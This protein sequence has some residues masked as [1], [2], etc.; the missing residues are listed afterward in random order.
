MAIALNKALWKACCSSRGT[1]EAAD[2]KNYLLAILFLKYLSDVK[3]HTDT[4]NFHLPEVSTFD[5]LFQNRFKSNIGALIN[6]ALHQLAASNQSLLKDV[7]VNF[8]FDCEARL[9][10]VKERGRILRSVLEAFRPLNLSQRQVQTPDVMGD[11]YEYLLGQFAAGSGRKAGEYYTPPG[12]ADLLVALVD[13]QVGET[14]CDPTCGTGSLLIRCGSH[15]KAKG[16]NQFHLYGQEITPTT[17]ALAKMNMLLHGMMGSFIEQGDTLR[18]PQ[19]L[20]QN[21]Q[22]MTFDIVIANPPFSGTNWG[23]DAAQRDPFHRFKRGLPPNSRG[24]YA[25]ISHMVET[26]DPKTG[27]VC[28][29]VPNAALYRKGGE[30]QIRRA[31]VDENLVDCVIKLP[32]NL[33]FGTTISASILLL[34]RKK[35]DEK[36]LFIAAE[37]FYEKAR[38]QN[39]LNRDHLKEIVALYKGRQSV[40]GVSFL[41]DHRT[42]E[43]MGYDLNVSRYVSPQKDQHTSDP[44]EL[45]QELAKAEANYQATW[46]EIKEVVEELGYAI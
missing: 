32:G 18:E 6:Q 36:T 4:V 3:G 25:F 35:G 28:V 13:P 29:I 27:R 12:I 37:D 46:Q 8:D 42:I 34:R 33:F 45:F 39:I 23:R 30:G 31:L 1:L 43:S 7:F 21:E 41:S 26:M 19:F 22:L 38:K 24:D 10:D 2:Y 15:L 14:I 5:S 9:G 17:W 11:A 40:S 20:K 16:A 44:G